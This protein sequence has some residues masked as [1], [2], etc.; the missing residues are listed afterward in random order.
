MGALNDFVPCVTRWWLGMGEEE[1]LAKEELSKGR[2]VEGKAAKDKVAGEGDQEVEH[3]EQGKD[4]GGIVR[5]EGT[6]WGSL[7][8]RQ[9]EEKGDEDD[10][11]D[12]TTA[13]V[14]GEDRGNSGNEMKT[15]SGLSTTSSPED[16][17]ETFVSRQL[18]FS[19]TPSNTFYNYDDE[20]KDYELLKRGV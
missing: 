17:G 3:G 18:Q 9:G 5:E 7:S 20:K 13:T 4:T 8:L 16:E 2:A 14:Q 11:E 6:Y 10:V 15:A 1:R 19:A 12:D